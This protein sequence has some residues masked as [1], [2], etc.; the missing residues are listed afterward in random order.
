MEQQNN[1]EIETP[2]ENKITKKYFFVNTE[3]I[4]HT[5]GEIIEKFNLNSNDTI[6]L[7]QSK[8]SKRISIES[9]KK[10]V[11]CGA[12]IEFETVE[13]DVNNSMDIQIAISLAATVINQKAKHPEYEYYIHAQKIDAISLA[14]YII[15][16]IT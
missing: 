1:L 12:Q 14:Q 2:I 13:I 4:N 11:Y 8:N 9:M 16:K 6:I 15:D 3:N 7:M 10:L 5:F